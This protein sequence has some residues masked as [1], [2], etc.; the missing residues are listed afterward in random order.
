MP[1]INPPIPIPIKVPVAIKGLV[2]IYK[3]LS[4]KGCFPPWY[5]N[6]TIIENMA[7]GSVV[8]NRLNNKSGPNSDALIRT[9]VPELQKGQAPAVRDAI[10][11]SNKITI[12]ILFNDGC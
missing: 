12:L 10:T 4:L 8:M 7:K 6:T 11:K 2:F 9:A 3:C 5:I 1:S